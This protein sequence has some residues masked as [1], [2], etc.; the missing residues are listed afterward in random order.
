MVTP[1]IYGNL[2]VSEAC[3]TERALAKIPYTRN[4]YFGERSQALSL[5]NLPLLDAEI[6]RK[7]FV[8]TFTFVS[9]LHY[10]RADWSINCKPPIFIFDAAM[11][12]TITDVGDDGEMN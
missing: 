10:A 5:L 2:N 12:C 11:L 6:F 9:M 1:D 3:S 8:S 4:T 7:L